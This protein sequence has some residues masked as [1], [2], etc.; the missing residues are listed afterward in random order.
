LT[1]Y[2]RQ[3]PDAPLDPDIVALQA[4][5]RK[6]SE[7]FGAGHASLTPAGDSCDLT[8][9]DAGEPATEAELLALLRQR[10]GDAHE[11]ASCRG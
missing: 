1:V 5:A 2:V 9:D 11:E 6:A 8:W 4:L 10:R 7:R 3:A